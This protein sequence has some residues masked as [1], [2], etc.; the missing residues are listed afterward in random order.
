MYE[1]FP[2]YYFSTPPTLNT[3]V[4][5][6][7]CLKVSEGLSEM[8]R[9][10]M[11]NAL[12]PFVLLLSV[13]YPSHSTSDIDTF[14]YGGCSRQKYEPNSPYQ[15]NVESVL[16]SAVNS[17]TYSSFNNY[18]VTGSSPQDVVYGLYQCR[19]DLSMPAC[20]T[21]VARAVTQI[22]TLCSATCGG[23]VQLQ[24]CYLKYDNASFLGVEDKTVVLK[25]CGPSIGYAP[26]SMVQRDAVLSSLSVEDGVYRVGVSGQ[27][28]GV[29]QCLS[30]LSVGECQDCVSEAIVR[31]RSDCVTSLYGDVYLAKC[32]VK[33]SS[34]GTNMY[35]P[36]H[37][38]YHDDNKQ[39]DHHYFKPL[40]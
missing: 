13:S 5:H 22:G 16:T 14:V 8:E 23:A 15:S 37:N 28:Q 4:R 30:D 19:G 18:T 26:G 9:R 11:L 29:S 34:S 20:A 7:H 32:Y 31:L 2:L 3:S 27:I 17:A 40:N 12:L 6:S 33:Y 24:G 21:C 10:R 38:Y 36:D 39:G 25:K 35:S 1:I